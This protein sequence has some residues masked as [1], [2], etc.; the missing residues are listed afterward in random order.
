MSEL[1]VTI[2]QK[3]EEP[4]WES[5]VAEHFDSTIYHTLMWIKTLSNESGQNN[6][7]L[8]CRDEKNRIVGV[9]PLLFTKGFPFGFGGLPASKRLS[10]LPRTPVGGPLTTN[11]K[12]KNLLIDQS[13]EIVS[14]Y[15]ETKLQLKI[16]GEKLNYSKNNFEAVP[17]RETYI[18]E[19]PPE[20]EEIRFGNSRNHSAIKR[21][22]N[23]AIRSGL[24]IRSIQTIDD[25]KIWYSMY[26][27]TM[28][29]HV[30][31]ARSFE[32]FKNLW[33]TFAPKNLI[34]IDL[35]ELENNQILAGSIF[36]LYNKTVIYGFN[37]SKRDLFDY[38]PNDL[39]HWNAIH[40]AQKL[41]YKYYDMGE[42]QQNQEGLAAY[43][44]KWCNV[45]KQIYHYYYPLEENKMQ[46]S[47]DQPTTSNF[48]Q[49][50]WKFIPLK[51]TEIIGNKIYKYL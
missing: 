35:A 12:A 3:I 7:N 21:A 20:N 19:I 24:K 2:L 16:I 49:K 18:Y 38:R 44:S 13:I 1:K 26:L 45:T 15:K 39:L 14:R 5:F 32:F 41:G 48:K 9:M 25:L 47:I 17:W 36:F 29:F 8:V 37:G 28:A 27:E 51:V 31:P 46:Q 10:S 34:R 42:V 6:I 22:V 50:I 11:D 33:E 30:T 40:E 4:E 43:K 23:K